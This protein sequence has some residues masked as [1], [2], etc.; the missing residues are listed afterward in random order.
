MSLDSQNN[1]LV[2]ELGGKEN[3]EEI[4]CKT[5]IIHSLMFD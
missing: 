5:D 4:F 1:R 2:D 3:Y